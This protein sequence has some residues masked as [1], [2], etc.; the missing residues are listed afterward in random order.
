MIGMPCARLALDR[1]AVVG[2]AVGECRVSLSDTP[3]NAESLIGCF[4]LN[5]VLGAEVNEEVDAGRLFPAGLAAE[6]GRFRWSPRAMP[7]RFHGQPQNRRNGCLE[8]VQHLGGMI[9]AIHACRS[10]MLRSIAVLSDGP[11][12]TPTSR[13]WTGPRN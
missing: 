3:N 2:D 7:D 9:R 1:M 11:C 10:M 13:T 6:C 4:R 12:K 5:V 8:L